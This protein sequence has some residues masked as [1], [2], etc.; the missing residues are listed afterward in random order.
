M[1]TTIAV[2]TKIAGNITLP[3]CYHSYSTY[4]SHVFY[5]VNPLGCPE[6]LIG[7]FQLNTPLTFHCLVFTGFNLGLSTFLSL[8]WSHKAHVV[9]MIF[10]IF[11]VLG[12][13]LFLKC[14][15]LTKY[16]RN[17]VFFFLV[18]PELTT[19][20]TFKKF[21]TQLVNTIIVQMQFNAVIYARQDYSV[22]YYYYQFFPV[23]NQ[24]KVYFVY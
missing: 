21:Q 20:F 8:S 14:S 10:Y 15:T 9:K 13:S 24:V 6:C 5:A 4:I 3:V 22:Q 17:F 18:Y 7:Y 12:K 19:G 16:F 11:L 23:S 2:V 1:F